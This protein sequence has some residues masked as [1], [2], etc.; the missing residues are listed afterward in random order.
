MRKIAVFAVGFV[1]LLAGCAS[2]QEGSRTEVDGPVVS[3]GD[4]LEDREFTDDEIDS[5][6]RAYLDV[7][8]I[9]QSYRTEIQN[10]ESEEQRDQ[11]S[12]ESTIDSEEA[13]QEHGIT[14]DTYNAI[15][16]RLPDNEQLRGRVQ[17]AIQQVEQERVEQTQQQLDETEESPEGE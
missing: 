5:F 16:V 3:Q 10:A 11:L 8:T 9:Q 12:R 7:T 17:E 2:Q 4:N 14:P 15:A 6:A 13:M 1:L